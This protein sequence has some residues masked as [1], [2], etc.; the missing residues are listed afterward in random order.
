MLFLCMTVSLDIWLEYFFD[1]LICLFLLKEKLEALLK[2][3]DKK[4]EL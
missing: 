2:I 1:K 4:A 3:K